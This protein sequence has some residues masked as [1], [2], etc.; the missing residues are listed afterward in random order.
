MVY[1]HYVIDTNDNFHFLGIGEKL[2]PVL[3]QIEVA[4]LNKYLNQNIKINNLFIN[5]ASW[6]TL[7]KLLGTS[8]LRKTIL[9]RMRKNVA[10][11]F[12]QRTFFCFFL[13]LF[14]SSPLVSEV[15]WSTTC[16]FASNVKALILPGLSVSSISSRAMNYVWKLLINSSISS[17]LS[18]CT[19]SNNVNTWSVEASR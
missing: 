3:L 12:D 7:V 18:L 6:S 19:A 1:S 2:P 11:P 14:V 17:S 4:L 13:F 9:S 5:I 8:A 10:F 15:S 16:T